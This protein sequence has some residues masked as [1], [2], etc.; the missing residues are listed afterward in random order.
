[1]EAFF[2]LAAA[3]A[4]WLICA[5]SSSPTLKISMV[6]MHFLIY[7]LQLGWGVVVAWRLGENYELGRYNRGLIYERRG[8]KWGSE[9]RAASRLDSR[10][11]MNT[12]S[13]PGRAPLGGAER[14]RAG[15]NPNQGIPLEGDMP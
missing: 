10:C 15:E 14:R 11:D 1:M 6:M 8:S 4:P 2:S 12:L 7:I 13:L 5:I 9:V 3:I